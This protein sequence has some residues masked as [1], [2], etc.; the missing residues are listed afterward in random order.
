M[1][2]GTRR[3]FPE[4]KAE[5]LGKQAEALREKLAAAKALEVRANEYG[6]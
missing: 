2:Q 3:F 1:G 5:G 4:L 6:M